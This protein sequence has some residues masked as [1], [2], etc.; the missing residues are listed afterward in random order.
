MIFLNFFAERGRAHSS[1]AQIPLL[2][3]MFCCIFGVNWR[4]VACHFRCEL[5]IFSVFTLGFF[6]SSFSILLAVDFSEGVPE[7]RTV[8]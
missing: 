3:S 1:Y 4:L 2:N 6:I 5:L 7:I 8:C